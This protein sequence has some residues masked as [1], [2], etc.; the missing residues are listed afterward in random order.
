MHIYYIYI[1]YIRT[2]T[3]TCFP[4]ATVSIGWGPGFPARLLADAWLL[5]QNLFLRDNF[6]MWSGAPL[7]N[8]NKVRVERAGDA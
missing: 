7:G 1:V 3:A 2:P 5:R 4:P 6:T 8:M